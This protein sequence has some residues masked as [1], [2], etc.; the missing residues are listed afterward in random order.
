MNHFHTN[1]PLL[2]FVKTCA[3]WLAC[4]LTCFLPARAADLLYATGGGVG[5]LSALY[6]LDTQTGT[7]TLMWNFA[8]A[9][10]YAGG[11]AYDR[12]SDI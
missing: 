1:A 5:E 8:G 3:A 7:P 11:L 4:V 2:G 10:I 9:P 6:T 12:A